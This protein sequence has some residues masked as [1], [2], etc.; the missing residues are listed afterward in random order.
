MARNAADLT[1]QD[2]SN[3]STRFTVPWSGAAFDTAGWHNSVSNTSRLT[4]PVGINYVRVS[5]SIRLTNVATSGQGA[6]IQ[7]YKNGIEFGWPGRTGQITGGQFTES[8]LTLASGPI[9]VIAGDYFEVLIFQY[10]T[11]NAT[12][13][14]LDSYFAIETVQ[15]SGP[16]GAPGSATNTG[17]TGATGSVGAVGPI[18]FTGPTGVTGPLG[19]GPTGPPGTATNTGATGPTGSSSGAMLLG[20][21]GQNLSGGVYSTPYQYPTGSFTVDFSLNPIQWVN[22]AGAFTIGAP[23]Q[24]GSCIL[25]IFNQTGAGAITFPGWTVGN[26][27]DAFTTIAGHKFALM[28]WG[29]NGIYSYSVKALQ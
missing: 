14:A 28:M 21:T 25:M 13:V 27:G 15:S 18:G 5:A 17:A 12:I 9:P 24:A 1:G 29:C 6:H 10:N 20:A 22:N 8:W 2:I 11:V 16:T 19:T 3:S 23:S 4:V 7:F 26:P